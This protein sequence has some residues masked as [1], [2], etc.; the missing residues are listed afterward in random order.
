MSCGSTWVWGIYAV[1]V[2]RTL[3]GAR[4]RGFHST[5]L[6]ALAGDR[7]HCAGNAAI[8][9][10]MA[11]QFYLRSSA[12][13]MGRLTSSLVAPVPLI[14]VSLLLSPLPEGDIQ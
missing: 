3:K 14:A 10:F 9:H 7:E 6:F 2:L 1:Y 8:I 11:D 13:F 5:A 12:P 4:V